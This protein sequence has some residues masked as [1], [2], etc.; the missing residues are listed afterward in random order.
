MFAR[1]VKFVA[2]ANAVRIVLTALKCVTEAASIWNMT[3]KIAVDAETFVQMARFARAAS[4]RSTAVQAI[5]IVKAFVSIFRRIM[6]TVVLV[7]M[8][9]LTVRYVM[10]AVVRQ[11]V[12]IIW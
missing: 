5:P 8:P 6:P 3:T 2:T 7:A 9:V 11:N 1:A 10:A 12:M 4:V